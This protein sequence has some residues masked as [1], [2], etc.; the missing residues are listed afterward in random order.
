E[1]VTLGGVNPGSATVTLR[2][3][4]GATQALAIIVAPAQTFATG[5]PSGLVLAVGTAG[6]QSYSVSGGVAPYTVASSNP[7][8]LSATVSG[9][10]VTLTG[11]S[12]GSANVIVSDSAG[13][14]LSV[15]VSVT[16]SAGQ[17]LFT[18]APSSLTV[19][20]GTTP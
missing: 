4:G 10:R 9:N 19:S 8:V 6:A 5:I 1:S 7:N 3:A 11:L 15:Q 2:D 14:S 18:T 20:R 16:A 12:A 17:A 13:S